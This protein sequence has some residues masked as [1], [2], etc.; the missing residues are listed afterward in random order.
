MSEKCHNKI[1]NK[2]TEEV[3]ILPGV[4]NFVFFG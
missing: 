3:R 2:K 1:E 4:S